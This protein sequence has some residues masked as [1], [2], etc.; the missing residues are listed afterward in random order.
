MNKPK[1][2]KASRQAEQREIEI[3]MP[4]VLETMGWRSRRASEHPAIPSSVHPE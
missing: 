4:M 3:P 1:F 2:L